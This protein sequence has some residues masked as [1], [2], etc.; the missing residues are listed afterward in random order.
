ML[1]TWLSTV[2]SKMK[3]LALISYVEAE[4]TGHVVLTISRP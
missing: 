4:Q 3:S 2:R 1:R